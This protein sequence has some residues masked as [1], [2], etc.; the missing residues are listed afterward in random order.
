MHASRSRTLL[1][2][3]IVLTA[4]GCSNT[5]VNTGDDT[6]QTEAAPPTAST[7]PSNDKLVNAFDFYTDA[8]GHTGYYFTPP[9]AGWRCVIVPRAW[10]GCQSTSGGIGITGAPT[11]VTDDQGQTATPNSIVVRTEGDP[12][13][14]SMPADRFT[15][16]PGPAKTLPLNK[17]LAAAGFR[18]NVQEAGISCLSEQTDKG[19][20]F[21]SS[22]AGWQYT[23]VP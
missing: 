18:C 21:S 4:V 6:R 12:Q 11:S 20:T 17:V 7:R 16:T 15:P 14:A 22:G 3:V 23:D 19:F 10:A 2:A 5:V 13:F 1:A 9:S 8:T